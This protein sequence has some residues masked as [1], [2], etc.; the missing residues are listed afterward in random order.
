MPFVFLASQCRRRLPSDPTSRGRPCLGLVVSFMYA[1]AHEGEPPT[2]DFHPHT[3]A[4]A[5]RTPAL[6]ADRFAGHLILDFVIS[7]RSRR[8]K[9]AV[10][11]TRSRRLVLLN[12]TRKEDSVLR[13]CPLSLRGGGVIGNDGVSSTQQALGNRGAR[14]T[15]GG[16]GRGW[17]R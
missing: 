4:H 3:H 7:C 1:C 5:G 17:V 6:A 8:L 12:V 2:G 13:S 11:A 14:W 10:T 9:R 15:D 16:E